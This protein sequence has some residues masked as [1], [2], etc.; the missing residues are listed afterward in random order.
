MQ[1]TEENWGMRCACPL[2]YNLEATLEIKQQ[3]R[4]SNIEKLW[5]Y[6][7]RDLF[8]FAME[9]HREAIGEFGK[10]EHEPL[11]SQNHQCGTGQI[12]HFGSLI[13]CFG[14]LMDGN[15]WGLRNTPVYTYVRRIHGVKIPRTED[16][17]LKGFKIPEEYHCQNGWIYVPA[18]WGNDVIRLVRQRI[19]K[20]EFDAET[21]RLKHLMWTPAPK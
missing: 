18:G 3:P 14:L 21:P 2:P 7:I 10:P 5:W 11:W 20:V 13:R 15:E 16:F 9:A 4:Y 17:S 12:N 1:K 6:S 19:H 8:D